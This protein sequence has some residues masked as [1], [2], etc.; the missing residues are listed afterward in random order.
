M[1]NVNSLLSSTKSNNVNW[2]CCCLTLLLCCITGTTCLGFDSPTVHRRRCSLLLDYTKASSSKAAK[3]RIQPDTCLYARSSTEIQSSVPMDDVMSNTAIQLP[4]IRILPRRSVQ[5]VRRLLE[6]AIAARTAATRTTGIATTTTTRSSTKL[7]TLDWA[8]FVTYFCTVVT[9]CF[10]FVTLPSIAA[11]YVTHPEAVTAFVAGVASI[12][13]L[14]GGVGKLV[15]GFVCERIGGK[16]S[17]WIYLIGLGCLSLFLSNAKSAASIGLLLAACE[18]LTSIQWT[19]AISILD[20]HY[21]DQPAKMAR[22]IALISTASAGGAM[23][24]KTGGAALM[25]LSSWRTLVQCGAGVA[26]LGAM[27]MML[28]VKSQ[29]SKKQR[30][31][32]FVSSPS[33]MA[34]VVKEGPSPP[35]AVSTTSSNMGKSKAS[36]ASCL[37]AMFKNP[38]FWMIGL[39]N[40]IGYV[41]RSDS[42]LSA[43]LVSTTALPSKSTSYRMEILALLYWHWP[44]LLTTRFHLILSC[45]VLL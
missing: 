13:P 38:I 16:R 18:F 42:M 36:L 29:T 21:Q 9:S 26:F 35:Q 45:Y 15:N 23:L 3:L 1:S 33:Q 44:C 5:K 19:S 7:D 12:A 17:S 6:Q 10:M 34:V 41:A 20:V 4:R 39:A 30:E 31:R 40:T 32:T 22:G 8:L 37:K 25:K 28:G 43:F 14:G 24:A 27:C 11:E 2:R